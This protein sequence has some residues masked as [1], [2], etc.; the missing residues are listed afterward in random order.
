MTIQK[1]IKIPLEEVQTEKARSM[2]ISNSFCCAICG[3]KL[4]EG[5]E[6]KYIQLL[7]TGEIVSTAEDIENSQGF[8][9]VGSE[10]VKRLVINFSF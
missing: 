6:Y 3:K 10:C 5:K 8:F 2:D 7:T 4:K 1:I 9:P